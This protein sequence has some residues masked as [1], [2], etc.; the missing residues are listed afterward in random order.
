MNYSIV[1][2]PPEGQ[3]GA[4]RVVARTTSLEAALLILRVSEERVGKRFGERTRYGIV[5]LRTGE[6]VPAAG[7]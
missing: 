6:A 3:V 2:Y 7:R 1:E 5:S 4:Q